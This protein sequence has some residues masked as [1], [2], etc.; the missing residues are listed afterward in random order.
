[1]DDPDYPDLGAGDP[2]YEVV[3]IE[4]K[5]QFARRARFRYPSHQGETGEQFG[6]SDNVVHYMLGGDGVIK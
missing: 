1:M 2:V 6:L 3:G 5:N 4:G